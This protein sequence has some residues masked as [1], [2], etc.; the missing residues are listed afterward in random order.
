MILSQVCHKSQIVTDISSVDRY[1][2]S[3][4]EL[5]WLPFR[6]PGSEDSEW[7][8]HST[9]YANCKR[10]P[11]VGLDGLDGWGGHQEADC[12]FLSNGPMQINAHFKFQISNI[13]NSAA[14]QWCSVGSYSTRTSTGTVCGSREV[15]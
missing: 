8:I 14:A 9:G 12:V 5:K 10:P 3:I 2:R 7:H 4:I 11:R 13:S 6:Q 15:R 1:R